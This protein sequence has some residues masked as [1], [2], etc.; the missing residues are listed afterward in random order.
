[1]LLLCLCFRAM[2][3]PMCKKCVYS[4]GWT[5]AQWKASDPFANECCGCKTCSASPIDIGVDVDVLRVTLTTLLP[6]GPRGR[7]KFAEFV[8][9]WVDHLPAQVRKHMSYHGALKTRWRLDPVHHTD[10]FDGSESFD[11]SNVVYART[12]LLIAPELA[13]NYNTEHLGDIIEAWLGLAYLHN[14][15]AQQNLVHD[16]A[17]HDIILSMSAWIEEL[18]Y[19][20]YWYSRV[21]RDH[22][23][24]P[25]A[26]SSALLRELGATEQHGARR[27]T[28]VAWAH[29][30]LS[31]PPSPPPP[32]PP[33]PSSSSSISSSCSSSI[34]C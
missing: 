10:G 5:P 9:F 11:P 31:A 25:L 22:W 30:P 15:H 18:S 34:S 1:M 6:S 4:K 20:V 29:V 12:I 3:C 19:T 21:Q 16:R 26:W 13:S 23:T 8:H 2:Q 27:G 33:P 17:T 7:A 14:Q 32:S 24:A 28:A